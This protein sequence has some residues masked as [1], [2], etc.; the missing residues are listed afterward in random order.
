MTSDLLLT[1]AFLVVAATFILPRG[2]VIFGGF[3]AKLSS[4]TVV[5]VSLLSLIYSIYAQP[6]SLSFILFLIALWLVLN[7][8]Q[9]ASAG[10]FF[11]FSLIF[12]GLM[13]F[14]LLFK[15][16]LLAEI[17]AVL[18]FALLTAGF[19]TRFFQSRYGT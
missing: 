6:L 18:A 16:I 9:T 7:Y 8:L 2:K 3:V 10:K 17:L 11:H 5:V 12:L 13:I 14:F 19:F 4:L 15:M 1:I